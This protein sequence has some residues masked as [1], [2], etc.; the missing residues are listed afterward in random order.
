MINPYINDAFYVALVLAVIHLFSPHI[1]RLPFIPESKMASFAGGIA[2]SYVFLHMIPEL[3][4]SKETIGNILIK[5]F[6]HQSMA[7][8]G[9]FFVALIGFTVF[10]GLEKLAR[11]KGNP[12]T[13]KPSPA[14]YHV[15]LLAFGIYNAVISYTLPLRLM[16]GEAFVVIFTVVAMGLHFMLIDRHMHNRFP[17][18]YTHLGRFILTFALLIGWGMAFLTEIKHQEVASFLTAFL[19]G[20]ILLNVIRDELSFDRTSSFVWFTIGMLFY[21]GLLFLATAPA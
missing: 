19:A 2:V 16:A 17:D 6:K 21:S 10:Y 5:T 12:N 14:V 4:L 13:D 8:L 1:R 9:I 20:S 7:E 15:H 11:S 18:Q 3:A